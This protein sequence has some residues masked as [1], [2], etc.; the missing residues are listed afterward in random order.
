MEMQLNSLTNA[1][2]EHILILP[3]FQVS[4]TSLI[5]HL[6]EL[7]INLTYIHFFIS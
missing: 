6:K 4:I 1:C 7:Y 5:I 2:V 3:N